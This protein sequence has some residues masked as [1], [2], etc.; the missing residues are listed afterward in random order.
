MVFRHEG[1]CVAMRVSES[2]TRTSAGFQAIDLAEA[3]HS[4]PDGTGCRICR[5]RC[6]NPRTRNR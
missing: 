1:R 4:D 2:K 5:S 6:L 3:R